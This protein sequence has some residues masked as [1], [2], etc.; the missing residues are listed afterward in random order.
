M[1]IQNT[2]VSEIESI[3]KA[4]RAYFASNATLDRKFRKI[5]LKK[6][7]KALKE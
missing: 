6:L 5:Q 1:S 4:Q 2:P 3:V 7:Q